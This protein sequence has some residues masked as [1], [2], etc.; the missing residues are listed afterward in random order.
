MLTYPLTLDEWRALK[1]A[2]RHRRYIERQVELD[3]DDTAYV[4]ALDRDDP[5]DWRAPAR[6]AMHA[7]RSA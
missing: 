5:E 6:N 1:R 3:E 2:T 7:A 4:D